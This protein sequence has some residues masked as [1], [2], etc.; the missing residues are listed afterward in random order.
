VSI[1]APSAVSSA[2]VTD[3]SGVTSWPGIPKEY[4]ARTRAQDARVEKA[5]KECRRYH[6]HGDTGSKQHYPVGES[7]VTQ[8]DNAFIQC[9]RVPWYKWSCRG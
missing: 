4:V 5:L 1:V 6:C 7:E 2:I 8:F 9:W 3:L